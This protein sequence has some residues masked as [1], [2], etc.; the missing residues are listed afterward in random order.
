MIG[1]LIAG[2]ALL[3]L[4]MVLALTMS[5]LG[6]RESSGTQEVIVDAPRD[7]V[8]DLLTDVASF[9]QWQASVDDV[10]QND[11]GP[12]RVRRWD[13][14]EI[15]LHL[16]DN[17]PPRSLTWRLAETNDAF[18]ETWSIQLE[19][20]GGS[21]RIRGR[22]RDEIESVFSRLLAGVRGGRDVEF[23]EFLRSLKD[24]LEQPEPEAPGPSTGGPDGR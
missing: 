16:I 4:F 22:R 11:G 20:M 6:R 5:A 23:V 1:Y 18:S 24:Y 15:K 9:P 10:E 8:W 19:D 12:W 17:D 3:G 7:R 2:V 13:K 21:T 14:V